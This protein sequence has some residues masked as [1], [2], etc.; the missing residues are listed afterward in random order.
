MK[1]KAVRL[2]G[3]N[4]L[5]LEEF[6]LPKIKDDEILAKVVC[7]SICMSSYKASHE[8][9]IH[10]RV[11]RDIAQ[12]PVIIGHEFAGELVEVGSK[13]SGRFKAGD[14]FSIQPALNYEKGPVGVLSAPGYSYRFIGGDATYVVIPNEVMEQGCLLPFTGEGYY[15]A[16][17]S[18]PLSCVIGAMHA[19]YHITP[20][21]YKHDMEI[22][23]G[24]NMA[25]LAGVGPMGLAAINYAIHR[26]DR[27]PKLMVVTDIDQTRLDRAASLYSP[28][29]A[30]KNGIELKYVNTGSMADPVEGLKALTDGKG[31]NDV[32]VFAPV[33]AVVEQADAI[34]S[35]DGCLN[36]FAGPAKT[37]FKAP[38][39]FYNV[40]Y[41]YTHVVGTSGGNTD[42]MKEALAMM[43]EG[44]DPAGL[45][46]HVGGINAVIDTTLNLPSIPGG[47]KLIYTHIDMPLTPIAEFEAKGKESPVYAELH[48]LCQQHKGLWNTEAEAY[49]LAHADKL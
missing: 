5:R 6:E 15:P 16:S 23:Q 10:K 4:D 32:F 40:H 27:K 36:F 29:E 24:G 46:T 33:A 47:K 28:E 38:F 22:K 39:N 13:W 44:L 7:D 43:N 12:N 3:K 31:Y 9:D 48:K 26:T 25:S 2:Y 35:F 19:N 11:P 18:E 49:L 21:S 20:G 41:A 14:K 1:T 37:D 42:D 30:A 34:L 8:A 45:V 17:L